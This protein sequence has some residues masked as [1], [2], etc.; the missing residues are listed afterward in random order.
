MW[1]CGEKM[2]KHFDEA[3]ACAFFFGQIYNSKLMDLS[4]AFVV[5]VA[6]ILALAFWPLVLSYYCAQTIVFHQPR[7]P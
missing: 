2:G 4:D 6:L 3:C 1:H 7:F 5:I